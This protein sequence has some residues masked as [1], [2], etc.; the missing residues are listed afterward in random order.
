MYEKYQMGT[1]NTV[2]VRNDNILFSLM[3]MHKRESQKHQQRVS[4]KKY[5]KTLLMLI[6]ANYISENILLRE[7]TSPFIRKI[8]CICIV[9][10][11]EFI[12][13]IL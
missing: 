5:E 13:F 10:S 1:Q 8:L 6:M 4:Y 12:I 7:N 2:S 11:A 3:P 9:H